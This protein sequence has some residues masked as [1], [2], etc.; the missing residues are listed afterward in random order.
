MICYDTLLKKLK[1]KVG[2]YG[3]QKIRN[4]NKVI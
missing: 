4:Y 3:K 2:I 1:R